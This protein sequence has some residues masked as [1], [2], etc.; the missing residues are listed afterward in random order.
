M[1]DDV[2]FALPL[3]DVG[4]GWLVPGLP[5]VGSTT[6]SGEAVGEAVGY[7]VGELVGEAVGDAVGDPVGESAGEEVGDAVA[8]GW[9]VPGLPVP[10]SMTLVVGEAVGYPAGE[11]VG[12]PV[13]EATGDPVGEATGEAVGSGFMGDGVSLPVLSGVGQAVP[14]APAVGRYSDDGVRIALLGVVVKKLVG[15]ALGG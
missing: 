1:G 4:A 12:E 7:P 11:L 5:V 8:A 15:V 3:G 6:P 2:G 14:S 9:L 10:G 13:G